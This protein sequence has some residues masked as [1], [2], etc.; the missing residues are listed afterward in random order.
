MCIAAYRAK[1]ALGEDSPR[2]QCPICG[3]PLPSSA[4]ACLVAGCRG[5]RPL[6]EPETI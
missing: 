2:H 4:E 6:G 5:I 1:P 3:A